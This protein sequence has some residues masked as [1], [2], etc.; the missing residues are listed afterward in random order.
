LPPEWGPAAWAAARRLSGA[1]AAATAV[2]TAHRIEGDKS[3]Q[4]ARM[5]KLWVRGLRY[6]PVEWRKGPG[7][8]AGAGRPASW[9]A[10]EPRT[11][12]AAAPVAAGPEF[13]VNTNT[14]GSQELFA[15]APH[16]VASDATGNFVVTW[17]SAG[18][19]G[20]AFGVYGQRY[21]ADGTR[22]G[23]EFRVNQTVTNSQ[24]Y[25][26]VACADDGSF[27]VVWTSALQDGS[28]DGVYARRYTA[29]GA[30]A[31]DEFRVNTTTASDQR[32]ANVAVA[33]GGAFVVT[34]SGLAQAGGAGWDVYAQ[35]YDP[36]G[37]RQG[38]EFRV[39]GTTAGDQQ[40][41]AVA[42]DNAGDFVVTW[43]AGGQDGSGTGVY[44][45][46]YS[47]AG[48]A[49]GAEFRVNTTTAGDQQYGRVAADANGNFVV[50]WASAGQ[51]G[52]GR[53]VYAQRYSAAGTKLGGE[54]RV[55]QVTAGEQFAPTVAGDDAGGF[56]VTWT[57]AQDGDLFGVFARAY[58]AGGTPRGGEFR[59]NTT[60]SG[61]QVYASAASSADGALA[62]VW[63][64]DGQDG[65]AFG[66]YGQRYAPPDTVAPTA[67]VVDVTPD[68]RAGGV[69]AVTVA[70]SEP[71]AGVDR[72]DLTLIR[73]G[74]SNLIGTAQSVSSTDGGKTW[75]LSGVASLTA[76]DGTYVLSLKS[77][78][79][80]I[81]DLSGN[82]LAGGA[83]DQW[84]VDAIRPTADVVDVTPDPRHDPVESST[85]RFSE[86]V[87]GF[88][89]SDLR[90]TRDGAALN[91]L[92]AAQTLTSTDGKAYTLG[93]LAAL[94][95]LPGVYTLALVAA[96]S[97]IVDGVG[98]P[99]A[100]DAADSWT[101]LPP[102]AKVVARHVFYG[103]SAFTRTAAAGS[104]PNRD[105]AAIATDKVALLPGVKATFA[106]YTSY[107]AGINGVM[108]DIA[109]LGAGLTATD[110]AVRVGS[111]LDAARWATGARPTSVSVRPG[112]GA[113][114]SDRVTLVWPDGAVR[115]EWMQLPVLPTAATRLA[116][117]DVF[118]FGNLPGETGDDAASA[119]V[120][121]GDVVLT[122][123]AI[124]A[125]AAPITSRYDFDRN[126]RVDARDMAI[127][128]RA[129]GGS[130]LPLLASMPAPAA[131]AS[132]APAARR[133][134]RPDG[135]SSVLFDGGEAGVQ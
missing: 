135:A 53:G 94:T 111:T 64:S 131:A 33:A 55:N 71:V 62:I 103:G 29:A 27:V 96:G 35:R 124:G 4:E 122:R 57:G 120:D 104:A 84:V 8:Q 100:G 107:P 67:D 106:N 88:G 73:N 80:G 18:Q 118:Y 22:R 14:A 115:G 132:T 1:H 46:R 134:Y 42:A 37:A 2:V 72:G 28:G 12:L 41:P 23:G 87:T 81:A 43:T 117:P 60:V 39:N 126:G 38:S 10:L 74:G 50:A 17:S 45:R 30:P 49:Q 77:S 61:N 76:A 51:D 13:R 78:G 21:A 86:R 25:P 130:A 5:G 89:A 65:S 52:S 26:G 113:N 48:A 40:F 54:F 69:D 19:D 36:A 82:A 34:W 93:N 16:A 110:F 95:A 92:T 123:K 90:L 59:V 119:V 125:G 15:E 116:A 44:A 97:G 11:L 128:R 6:A 112:A 63:E 3:A 7:W 91:L 79:T 98:N 127:V 83:S 68:P 101:V 32:H 99:V 9:E 75:V 47:A 105:D 114:G 85:I 109:G 108:V 70:F 24:W 133:G 66:V 56:V 58:D 129:A 31:G 121:A 102:P 20:S